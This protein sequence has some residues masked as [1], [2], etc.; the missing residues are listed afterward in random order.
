MILVTGRTGLVGSHLLLELVKAGRTV[1]ALKRPDSDQGYLARIFRYFNHGELLER[2]QWVE[3]DL[4]DIYS[5]EDALEGIDRVYHC[6]ALISFHKKD[7]N[8]LMRINA[9]GTANLINAALEKGTGKLCHVSS[10]AAIG[11]PE[12]SAEIIDENLFWKSSRYNTA[13]AISKYAAEREVWRGIEEGLNAVIVNPSI[14][15]GI[16]NPEKGSSRIFETVYKGLKFYPPGI[17]GFVDV[18][19]VT[20]IMI[21]L[22]DS[23]IKGKRFIAN[24]VNL[25]YRDLFRLI[26]AQYNR[27]APSIKTNRIMTGAAWRFEWL[28]SKLNG[29]QPLVTRETA[30]TSYNQFR[31]SNDNVRT[32]L[33]YS[34]RD[35]NDTISEYARYYKSTF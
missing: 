34:F 27:D 22:M 31:Y 10:I 4:M 20:A 32:A 6:A 5:L 25:P 35:I 18:R 3:G 8:G 21:K 23:D 28:R 26:A 12:S 16:S 14:V 24:A 17:N 19:D 1:R 29:T 33:N 15:L 2:I 13:Y 7:R 30:R 11:R 9:E